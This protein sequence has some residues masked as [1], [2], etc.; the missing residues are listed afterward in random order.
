[1]LVCKIRTMEHSARPG[2]DSSWPSFAAWRSLDRVAVLLLL[3]FF[4]GA[5][6]GA[7]WLAVAPAIIMH[8]V[9]ASS[10]WLGPQTILAG[11]ACILGGLITPVFVERYGRAGVMVVMALAESAAAAAY[12]L[13]VTLAASNM[14]IALVGFFAGGCCAAF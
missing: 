1:L 8:S 4:A 5:T 14:A 10:V 12:S 2:P 3:V 7:L 13:G 11:V 9:G 6:M